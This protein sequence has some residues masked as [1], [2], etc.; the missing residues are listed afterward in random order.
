MHFFHEMSLSTFSN[1][2]VLYK[3]PV[4]TRH[5]EADKLSDVV[6]ADAVFLARVVVTF[7]DVL[8]APV[9][10][11]ARG[12]FTAEQPQGV[13]RRA[14]PLCSQ[15]DAE[16]CAAAVVNLGF[17]CSVCDNLGKCTSRIMMNNERT[18]KLYLLLIYV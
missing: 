13:H 15:I 16:T 3:S 7:L 17:Y 9:V 5:T 6:N 8:Q 11:V 18:T 2:D 10:G 1:L 4:L 14:P 12:T